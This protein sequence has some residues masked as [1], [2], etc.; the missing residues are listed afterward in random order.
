MDRDFLG[1]DV[2][3]NV[4]RR[5]LAAFLIALAL[6]GG[7]AAAGGTVTEEAVYT[8]NGTPGPTLIG[9]QYQAFLTEGDSMAAGDGIPTTQGRWMISL[10]QYFNLSIFRAALGGTTSTQAKDTFLADAT[11]RNWIILI[12]TGHNNVNGPVVSDIQAMV[13]WMSALAPHY[14]VLSPVR[15][16]ADTPNSADIT[17]LRDALAT[18]FGVHYLDCN[19][20][21]AAAN[22]GS[23]GD[24][25]DVANGYTPRSLRGDNIHLNQAGQDVIF[26]CVRDGLVSLGYAANDEY[27]Y[28]FARAA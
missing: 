23:A 6:L 19:D 26:A 28:E 11:H 5:V 1:W 16:A 22:D 3:R 25:S 10:S 17:T 2:D 9:G 12:W 7:V 24:L 13:A 4:I 8:V 21:L 14:I 15:S 27:Y 20:D 18:A